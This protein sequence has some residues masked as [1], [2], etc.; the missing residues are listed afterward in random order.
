MDNENSTN[1]LKDIANFIS[2][3]TFQ[4]EEEKTV[5]YQYGQGEVDELE[6]LTIEDYAQVHVPDSM[7]DKLVNLQKIADAIE[8]LSTKTTLPEVPKRL[9]KIDY[10][11]SLNPSQYQATI[12]IKGP[13]LVIAGAGSGKTRTVTYRVSYLIESGVPPN[14][15]LLLTFTR[16]AAK[17]ML[18]RTARLL[19]DKRAEKVMSGT[20]HSFA[21]YLL[22]RYAKLIGVPPNFTII[23]QI[24]AQDVIDLIRNELKFNKKNKAFPRKQRIYSVISKSRNCGISIH[25]A[26]KK[27]FPAL[28]N[29]VEDIEVIAE[30]FR[31]YKKANKI[32]DFDDLMEV[33]RDALRDNELFRTKLQRHYKY[34]MVDEY[35]DT[36]VIQKEI[37]NY[38]A[39]KGGNLMVVGD[40]AQS[41]YAFRGANFENILTFPAS[42]PTCQIIKL[43]QNY[44]SNQDILNFTNAIA[45]SALLGY[46]KSLFSKNTN[47][48]KP[49]VS[50]F[51]DQQEEAIYIVN[52][53]LALREK[54]IELN[55]IAVL[56][57]SSF[58]GNFIQ[59][60]LLKRNIPYVVVGGIKFVERRQ[61][62]DVI[63]HLRLLVNPFDAV[64]WNRI[65][66]LIAGVGKVT[67][68]KIVTTIQENKGK[69][70]FTKYEKK[71][72]GEALTTL[73][74][75][76]NEAMKPDVPIP[77]KITILKN[78]YTPLL[79]S[80]EVDY[81]TRLQDIDM[82][83]TLSE[84]YVDLEKFLSDFALDPPS[85]KYQ[86][87]TTPL[88][89]DS[90][91]KPLTLSTI[92]SSK[93]LEW[94][95]VF[96]PHLLDG[97]LPSA[98]SLKNIEAFEEER[99][100]FYVACSRAKE[101]LYLT[102]PSYMS[103]WDSF[104]TKPSRF[105]MEIEKAY[106]HINT[107]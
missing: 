77:T 74:G 76:L 41:I 1:R 19:K 34:I 42:Y 11:N 86:N 44:R 38:I 8:E 21:N 36:N 28:V 87:S 58:H 17:E 22:R 54:D 53:I 25:A 66:K 6:Q 37:V 78:Y 27:E 91:D 94:Y 73:Q 105:I 2:T 103:I 43:E 51:Y 67:A 64:C 47:R 84:K 75:V 82:L 80:Q 95:A 79:K 102:M 59:G 5:T 70:D 81:E 107:K 33:V 101:Q 100:L 92:H 12:T 104:F 97:L 50:R 15:I 96:I 23:D 35:Q 63:A 10:K 39:G 52:K 68:G 93:G 26:I 65:L 24:D 16:K 89:E 98:R 69:I 60:E 61:I 32:F 7:E 14:Q 18:H 99:R 72:Y 83:Y 29:Y 9:Y 40:D 49:I 4:K 20:Y 56:Y 30:T 90:E 106:F 88:L 31:Q 13:V 45:N 71:K 62:K 55:Q 57:R 48:W 46:K 3:F 85:T